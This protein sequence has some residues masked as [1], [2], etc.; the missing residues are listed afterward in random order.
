MLESYEQAKGEVLNYL[1]SCIELA[2]RLKETSVAQQLERTALDIRN[3]RFKVA[4]V[5][6]IKRGKSTLINTLLGQDNDT[7]SPVNSAVCTGCI[8]YYMDLSVLTECESPHAKVYFYGKADPERVDF[9]DIED[10]ITED[11]NPN[12]RRGVARV[13]IYGHFPLLHSCCLVDTP[14]ANAVIERHGEMVYD[15]LPS[16]DAVIMAVM[17]GQAMT[18]SEA[19]MLQA[20]SGDE[21]RKIFY[22]LTQIDREDPTT[23]PQ[24]CDWVK[25]KIGDNGLSVPSS[26]YQVACKPVFDAL[27]KH[28]S[29]E[30]IQNLR[31]KWGV[32]ALES[33]VERF[34]L[35]SSLS[36]KALAQKAAEAVQKARQ[37]FEQRRQNNA[38]LIETQTV[39]ARS[40]AEERKHVEAEFKNL[41]VKMER[42]IADF[43]K[44]WNR[45]TEHAVNDLPHLAPRLQLRIQEQVSASKGVDAFTN[46]FQVGSMLRRC[47][48]E[49]ISEYTEKV[50][51]RYQKQVDKLDEDLQEE[52]G[53]FNSQVKGSG[54]AVA[55]GGSLVAVSA[56]A[57][58]VANA[59]P[60]GSAV[61]TAASAWV[62]ASYAVSAQAASA[63]VLGKI[64]LWLGIGG[65]KVVVTTKTIMAGLL[66]DSLI[67]AFVP[68]LIALVAMYLSPSI[69]RYIT[70]AAIPGKLED[71]LKEVAEK[72]RKQGEDYRNAFVEKLREKLD[73][74]EEEMKR[75]LDDISEKLAEL[76]PAVKEQAEQENQEIALLTTQGEDVRRQTYL[77]Q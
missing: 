72:L 30:E 13:E 75:Q 64:A 6:D 4:V 29:A 32:S 18:T 3:M 74:A 16:A 15:L 65:G 46:A 77:L 33:D 49:P 7:L 35:H 56:A 61:A 55:V 11:A 71:A 19:Q 53:Y 22:V 42:R 28:E 1:T 9:L 73:D 68:M 5:G 37:A 57:T 70:N 38:L 17:A 20:L 34:M 21:Q 51:E 69:A 43:E 60:F 76:D 40:L 67:A 31:G 25:K 63:G 58:A 24:I 41:R 52:L 36:G 2:H 26:I 48:Q 66:L 27:C 10:Y 59:V 62:T 44:R 47:I 54:S 8:V 39:D 12:N 50:V 14:G 45:I 23:L